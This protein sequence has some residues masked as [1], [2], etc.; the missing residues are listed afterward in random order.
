MLCACADSKP[1]LA[2]SALYEKPGKM[3]LAD[4]ILVIHFAL[5]VF[6]VAGLPLIWIGAALG[7]QWVRNPWFRLAHL[8]GILFVAFEAVIGMVCPLTTWEAELRD[9]QAPETGF[10][11]RYVGGLLFYDL[12]PW[13]FTFCYLGFALAVAL[14]YYQ[15]PPKRFRHRR[16]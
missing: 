15:F 6:I 7:W 3:Q 14:T 1:E 10:I 9:G 13:V 4:L 11:E 16:T 2:Y 12:P 5:V 8:T